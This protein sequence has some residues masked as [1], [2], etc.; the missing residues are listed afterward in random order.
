MKSSIG[1]I[2]S[3][4]RTG[5]PPLRCP[6]AEAWASAAAKRWITRRNDSY[7]GA[8][9]AW[10]DWL[11]GAANAVQDRL[12]F[13]S[14]AFY[15][16]RDISFWLRIAPISSSNRMFGGDVPVLQEDDRELVEEKSSAEDGG[17][18]TR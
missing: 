6:F 12:A 9:E 2:G 14:Q 7:A 15:A 3:E 8:P 10:S 16:I 5:P 11:F 17:S 4:E 18:D 1:L 13:V